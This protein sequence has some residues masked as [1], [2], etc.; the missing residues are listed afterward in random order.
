VVNSTKGQSVVIAAA[1]AGAVQTGTAP[2][3]Q[4]QVQAGKIQ[5]T[6]SCAACHGARLQ[7][8]SGPALTGSA[9]GKSHLTI[10]ALR[11]VVTKQMPLTAPGSLSASQYASIMAYVLAANGEKPSG[12]GTTPFPTT[13]RAEF[14]AVVLVGAVCTP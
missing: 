14:K 3:A 8:V 2:Y 5:Y 13:D 1:A 4:A 9:F 11:T 12:N 7:G 6:A 10:A